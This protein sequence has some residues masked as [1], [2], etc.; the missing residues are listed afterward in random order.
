MSRLPKAF[1]PLMQIMHVPALQGLI[2]RFEEPS[3]GARWDSPLCLA[4]DN[5]KD[6][7]ILYADT[8]VSFLSARTL[9]SS[10]IS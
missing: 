7:R 2:E 5:A 6:S 8:V 1:R 3:T 4:V 9:P 10:S